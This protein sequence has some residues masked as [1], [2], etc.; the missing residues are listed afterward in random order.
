MPPQRTIAAFALLAL[1]AL[2]ACSGDDDTASST[3]PPTSSDSSSPTG[4]G[5]PL[6][7]IADAAARDDATPIRVEGV[8]FLTDDETRL[9]GAIG[10]SFPVQ[11][12]G[13]S[14]SV[15]GVDPDDYALENGGPGVR[16][17]AGLVIVPGIMQDGALVTD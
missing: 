7:S 17:S 16:I 12:L 6:L 15:D 11:C 10:E 2:T 8:L 4:D 5:R 3:P 9:C 14:I 1:G 13:D